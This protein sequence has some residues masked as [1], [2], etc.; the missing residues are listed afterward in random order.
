LPHEGM[1][2]SQ[3]PWNVTREAMEIARPN[4]GFIGSPLG[5]MASQAGGRRA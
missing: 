4:D 5:A 1:L 2:P 3:K